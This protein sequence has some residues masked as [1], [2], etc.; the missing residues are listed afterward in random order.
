MSKQHIIIARLFIV[1]LFISFSAQAQKIEIGG[2]LGGM[3]YKGDVSTRL[4]PRFYRPAANMFFRYNATRS[5]SIRAGLAVGGYQAEDHYSNDPFQQAR[6]YSFRSRTSEATVDLQYNFLNYKLLPKV[7]NWT[8][9]VF[10]G[11]GL[12]SYTNAVV[13]ARALLNFP[14]GIGVKYEIKRPWSVGLEFGTRFT[15]ND[16]LDGLGE[17]TFGVTTNKIAQGNTALKDSYTYT[18]ITVSYTFYK[19]VCP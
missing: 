9:Y 12:Y 7:K 3:L 13:K 16:Y 14:L 19:I 15:N 6:N 18:A 1:G 17:R 11:I 4:N 8:P 2:G 5:F 10:G